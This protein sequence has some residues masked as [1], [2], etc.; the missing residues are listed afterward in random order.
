MKL[1]RRFRFCVT[2]NADLS[3][4]TYIFK[5]YIF[6]T[7]ASYIDFSR[8]KPSCP[9]LSCRSVLFFQDRS[10]QDMKNKYRPALQDRTVQD[11][12]RTGQPCPDDHL[13]SLLHFHSVWQYA[14]SFSVQ[15]IWSCEWC[16]NIATPG[17]EIAM[18]RRKLISRI[19][20]DTP[21][22]K[23]RWFYREKRL[24]GWIRRT[25]PPQLFERGIE[26]TQY[27][28]ASIPSVLDLILDT[29]L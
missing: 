12:R 18:N 5:W 21:L 19:H 28:Y 25:K 24:L 2:K 4:L 9:D 26:K 29:P 1:S 23:L 8:T 20:L 11:S 17:I 22:K 3:S 27:W 10:G 7:H 13:C 6:E 16:H 14:Y 15:M